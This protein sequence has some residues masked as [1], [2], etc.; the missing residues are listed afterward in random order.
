M[1]V[2]L[3]LTPRRPAGQFAWVSPEGTV[4]RDTVACVHCRAHWVIQPGSGRERG[5]CRNCMGPTCGGPLCMDDC[6][7]Y[8][9]QIEAIERADRMEANLRAIRR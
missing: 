2:P 3:L 6:V 4:E 1:G 8:W 5:F 9:Q 7:P